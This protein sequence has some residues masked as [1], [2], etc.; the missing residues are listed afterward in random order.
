M[1]VVEIDLSAE[2]PHH[3]HHALH[4]EQKIELTEKMMHHK[5]GFWYLGHLC[6][7]KLHDVRLSA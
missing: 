1:N 4:N 3:I 7:S 6:T 2:T 5:I